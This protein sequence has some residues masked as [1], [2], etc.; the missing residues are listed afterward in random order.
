M[1]PVIPPSLYHVDHG[2]NG[3]IE[4][5]GPLNLQLSGLQFCKSQL[6]P[7]LQGDTWNRTVAT[8]TVSEGCRCMQG[9]LRKKRQIFRKD[10]SQVMTSDAH[11]PPEKWLRSVR[12]PSLKPSDA[13]VSP[14][15]LHSI[16]SFASHFPIFTRGPKSVPDS[17]RVFFSPINGRA[18]LSCALFWINNVT[19]LRHWRFPRNSHEATVMKTLKTLLPFTTLCFYRYS[20]RSF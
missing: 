15:H 13:E 16:T 17:E 11:F 19:E 1:D 7:G 4:F 9:K 3:N 2:L 5:R 10:K 20:L 6:L 8:K 14:P 12:V 18:I